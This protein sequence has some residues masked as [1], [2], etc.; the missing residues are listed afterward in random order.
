[1]MKIFAKVAF[2]VVLSLLYAG[3][4]AA[5]SVAIPSGPP[6][7]PSPPPWMRP[8]S[9]IQGPLITTP[10]PYEDALV[11]NR[12]NMDFNDKGMAEGFWDA[13]PVLGA[14]RPPVLFDEGKILLSYFIGKLSHLENFPRTVGYYDPAKP[15]VRISRITADGRISSDSS[16]YFY[17]FLNHVAW[18]E[19][20]LKQVKNGEVMVSRAFYRYVMNFSIE[21][22]IAAAKVPFFYPATTIDTYIQRLKDFEK[23]YQEM[24]HALKEQRSAEE[25]K[26]SEAR[27]NSVIVPRSTPY[28]S[29]W[30]L[31]LPVR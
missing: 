15:H 1:M 22:I 18:S 3:T 31:G 10:A 17:D 30:H 5:L 7:A 28:V 4:H 8:I 11:F 2:I 29:R 26:H 12:P 13:S 14:V 19:R 21:K 25:K 24:L 20:L 9:S 16:G 6:L 27:R 23:K